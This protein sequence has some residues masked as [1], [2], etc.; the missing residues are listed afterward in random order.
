MI[1]VGLAAANTTRPPAVPGPAPGP[2][3]G[4]VHALLK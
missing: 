1:P 4:I 2:G 3:Q